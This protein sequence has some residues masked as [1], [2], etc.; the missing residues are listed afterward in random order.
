MALHAGVTTV[1][2]ARHVIETVNPIHLY[3]G[4]SVSQDRPSKEIQP[5]RLLCHKIR[6]TWFEE[7][8]TAEANARRIRDI[9]MYPR[10]QSCGNLFRWTGVKEGDVGRWIGK[11]SVSWRKVLRNSGRH[12][13]L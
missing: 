5:L 6:N 9:C 10:K 1:M 11:L 3:V 4:F 13:V 7:S 8:K 2:I 12:G